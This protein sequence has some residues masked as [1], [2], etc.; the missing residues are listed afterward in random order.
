MWEISKEQEEAELKVS[1][2]MSRQVVSVS[3]EESTAVAARL[4]AR[5]NVGC[6]PVCDSD[7]TLRGM[8]TDRDIVLRCV[9]ASAD[10]AA[11][12]VGTIMTSRVLSV[13]PEEDTH[14]AAEIMARE[15]VRRLPVADGM[16][17]VGM[18]SLADLVEKGHRNME[19]ADCLKE[20]CGNVVRH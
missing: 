10:P 19:A 18:I 15:Q 16:Q 7:G 1:E 12:K 2:L 5:T 20:I 9:A 13:S 11:T 8:L 6:L 4:L 17:V 3:P 14:R